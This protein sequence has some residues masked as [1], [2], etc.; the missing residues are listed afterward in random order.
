MV[1]RQTR[2][3]RQIS[4]SQI[5]LAGSV[6]VRLPLEVDSASAGSRLAVLVAALTAPVCLLPVAPPLELPAPDPA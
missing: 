3:A 5:Q 4:F 2:Q 6:V 1:F